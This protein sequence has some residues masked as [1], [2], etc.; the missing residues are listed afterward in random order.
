M[1]NKFTVIKNEDIERYLTKEQL[2]TLE[3]IKESIAWGRCKDNKKYDNT[4]LVVNKD[5]IYAELVQKLI[6]KKEKHKEESN[7]TLICHN[8]RKVYDYIP[9]ECECGNIFVDC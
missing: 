7:I 9:S 1:D 8:C 2:S 3:G 5:E 6:L 4:Y